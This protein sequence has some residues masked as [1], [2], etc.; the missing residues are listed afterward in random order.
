ME[1]NVKFSFITCVLSSCADVNEAPTDITLDATAV[2]ENA[3]VNTIVGTLTTTDPD[4]T[5]QTVG[6]L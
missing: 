3:P 6:M 2:K 5:P 4:P 1:Y